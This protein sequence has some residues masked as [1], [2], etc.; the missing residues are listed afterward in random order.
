MR[1]DSERVVQHLEAE[2][3]SIAR[4]RQLAH[5]IDVAEPSWHVYF[6]ASTRCLVAMPLWNPGRSLV[7]TDPDPHAL[8]FQMRHVEQEHESMPSPPEHGAGQQR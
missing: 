5:R 1:S 3:N 6:S 4:S 2:A 8:W 7:L